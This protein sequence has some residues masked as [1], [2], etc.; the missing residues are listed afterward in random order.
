MDDK[1]VL[2]E[3]FSLHK[4]WQK[5]IPY[6]EDQNIDDIQAFFTGKQLHCKIRNKFE[7]E[8]MYLEHGSLMEISVPR[9]IELTITLT[10]DSSVE[11][12][13]LLLICSPTE[14]SKD[15]DNLPL[16]IKLTKIIH[17]PEFGYRIAFDF[18]EAI[19]ASCSD[20]DDIKPE[21]QILWPDG[22]TTRIDKNSENFQWRKTSLY[23]NFPVGLG[24]Y[25]IRVKSFSEQEWSQ[26]LQFATKRK[27]NL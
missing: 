15:L 7:S 18:L 4:K 13:T 21:A 27:G 6:P 12:H 9:D 1:I 2:L 24:F 19:E 8:S 26:W 20:I 22:R 25:K 16:D 3:S 10:T 23:C 17:F 14:L 5:T 11:I